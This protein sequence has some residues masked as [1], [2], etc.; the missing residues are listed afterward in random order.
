MN[1][2]RSQRRE[3]RALREAGLNLRTVLQPAVPRTERDLARFFRAVPGKV[4][5]P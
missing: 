3:Q 1:S 5:I 2:N 4:P